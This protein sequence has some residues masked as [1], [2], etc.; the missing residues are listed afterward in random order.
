[1]L[2][3]RTVPPSTPAGLASAD[4][5]RV[6]Q[7]QLERC[8][9][10]LPLTGWLFD[11]RQ[12]A[13]R[14]KK[15]LASSFAPTSGIGFLK[16][17]TTNFSFGWNLEANRFSATLGQTTPE[18]DLQLLQSFRSDVWLPDTSNL[19]SLPRR[20]QRAL[21]YLNRLASSSTEIVCSQ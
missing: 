2:L 3:L 8:P 16:W 13:Q 20:L 17:R 9:N 18:Q 12:S 7:E 21:G 10:C 4:L 15:Q 19:R 1:M 6:A 14:P 5:H 11:D